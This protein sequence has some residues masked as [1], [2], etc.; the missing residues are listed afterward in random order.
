M[1]LLGFVREAS[2]ATDNIVLTV[3]S[4]KNN[5]SREFPNTFT[6]PSPRHREHGR[7]ESRKNV[8]ARRWGDS[9][10]NKSLLDMTWP[11]YSP[12]H[13]MCEY[14]HRTP[15][16]LDHQ[17]HCICVYLHRTIT[18][19]GH[20][21]F[22]WTK[23][24]S[25][26]PRTHYKLMILGKRPPFSSVVQLLWIA[27]CSCSFKQTSSNSVDHMHRNTK[28]AEGDKKKKRWVAAGGEDKC[29]Q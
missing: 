11:P 27:L 2:Y 26:S 25:W 20:Q 24:C 28:V 29:R 4:T 8:R 17:C 15:N 22:V 13:F 21:C 9:L 23:H 3:Q 14:L 12:T 6:S 10:Q 1:L 16:Q 19:S 5:D 7:R 18:Q